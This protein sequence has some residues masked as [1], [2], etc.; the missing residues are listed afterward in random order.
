M[1]ALA[2]LPSSFELKGREVDL[3][4]AAIASRELMDRHGLTSWH[5]KFD[6]ARVRF[7]SCNYGTRTISISRHLTALNTWENVANTVLHEI[8]PALAGVRVTDGHGSSTRMPLDA[9]RNAAM[10]QILL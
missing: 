2:A 8:A 3:R 6:N 1:R 10:T 7:G 4:E 5:F 9:R